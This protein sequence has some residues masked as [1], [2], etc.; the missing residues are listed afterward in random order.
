MKIVR[1]PS[2]LRILEIPSVRIEVAHD[3]DGLCCNQPLFD[4]DGK[5]HT[6]GPHYHMVEWDAHGVHFYAVSLANP[7]LDQIA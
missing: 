4:P 3:C 2:V 5:L 1:V 6:V 7:E